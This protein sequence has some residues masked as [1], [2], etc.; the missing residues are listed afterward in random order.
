M[1][2]CVSE[3]QFKVAS[4]NGKSLLEAMSP[5]DLSIEEEFKH[6]IEERSTIFAIYIKAN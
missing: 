4:N 2:Y 5:Q 6:F 1:A 3:D